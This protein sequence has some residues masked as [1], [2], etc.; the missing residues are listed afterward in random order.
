MFHAQALRFNGFVKNYTHRSKNQSQLFLVWQNYPII[1]NGNG[2]NGYLFFN[3]STKSTV[4]KARH[5]WRVVGY[6][7]AL[8]VNNQALTFI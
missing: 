6:D 5:L 8:R 2:H 3:G 1:R 7:A 4:F